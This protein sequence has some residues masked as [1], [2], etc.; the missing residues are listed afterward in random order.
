LSWPAICHHDAI[1]DK[2]SPSSSFFIASSCSPQNVRHL[3]PNWPSWRRHPNL[4]AATSISSPELM[5]RDR[6]NRAAVYSTLLEANVRIE[7][8]HAVARPSPSLVN[9]LGETSI[10]TFVSQCSLFVQ[11]R[12]LGSVL[13]FAGELFVIIYGSHRPQTLAAL[14]PTRSRDERYRLLLAPASDQSETHKSRNATTL[15]TCQLLA[16]LTWCHRYVCG[17]FSLEK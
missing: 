3:S 6:R 11:R 4:L 9:I 7:E 8:P 13:G 14:C 10:V 2:L 12:Y 15:S 1:W 16:C 17:R 5:T